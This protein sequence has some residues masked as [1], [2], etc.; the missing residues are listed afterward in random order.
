ML[1]ERP[2]I[3]LSVCI[4]AASAGRIPSGL[5]AAPPVTVTATIS[6]DPASFN[7]NCPK[8]IVFKAVIT[9]SAPC[10]V[11]YKFLR[12]DGG[13]KPVKS[14]VIPVSGKNI[15]DDTWTLGGTT[16]GWEAIQIISPAVYTSAHASFTLTCLPKP[17]ITGV[18]ATYSGFPTPE[19][20]IAGTNFGAAQGTRSVQVDGGPPPA[21]W[22]QY[23]WGDHHI[24][25]GGGVIPWE[26]VYQFAIVDGGSVISNVFPKRFLYKADGG[27]SPTSAHVGTQ[28]HI[29]FWTLPTPQGSLVLKM[30]TAV[31]PILSWDTTGI[32]AKVPGLSAGTYDIYLQKGGDVVSFKYPFQ[33]LPLMVVPKKK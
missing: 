3:L 29:Y 15:V 24:L 25:Y 17:N 4:L 6:A 19:L 5:S 32:N 22:T 1:K 13:I 10:T 11:Q 27:P 9:A 12:S 16:S 30:G 31:C 33:V 2:M 18:T 14:V 8:T 28:F 20:D 23:V 7:G 21:Y 26:H